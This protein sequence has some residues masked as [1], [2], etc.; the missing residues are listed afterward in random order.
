MDWG[1]AWEMFKANPFAGVG[2]GNFK[3]DFLEYKT[4]FFSSTRGAS[5]TSP[6]KRAAQAHNDYLQIAA[7]LGI[8]GIVALP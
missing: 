5:Y 7:E 3:V 6:V 1:T 8:P 4:I 2:L